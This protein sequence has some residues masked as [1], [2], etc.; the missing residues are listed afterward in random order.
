VNA[1]SVPVERANR[2]ELFFTSANGI[3]RHYLGWHGV[4]V[5]IFPI[6]QNVQLLRRL[7][8]NAARRC[9]N[10]ELALDWMPS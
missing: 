3:A 7:V 9:V 6:L 4:G 10:D 1:S 8:W 2:F 5:A